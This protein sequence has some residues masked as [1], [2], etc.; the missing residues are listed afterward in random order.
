MFSDFIE[1]QNTGDVEEPILPI[2]DVGKSV[3]NGVILKTQGLKWR[4]NF[5]LQNRKLFETYTRLASNSDVRLVIW[6]HFLVGRGCFDVEN[7]R[8]CIMDDYYAKQVYLPHFSSYNRQ[9]GSAIGALAAEVGRI[10]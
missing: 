4:L 10:A 8:F 5:D 6:L 9:R 2:I 3:E 7:R 1:D